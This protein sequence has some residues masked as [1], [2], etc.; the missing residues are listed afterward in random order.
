MSS[1]GTLGSTLPLGP[2]SFKCKHQAFPHDGSTGVKW[3]TSA[4]PPVTDNHHGAG[5]KGPTGCGR[6]AREFLGWHRSYL[7]SS[8]LLLQSLLLPILY[9]FGYYKKNKKIYPST[10]LLLGWANISPQVSGGLSVL[11]SYLEEIFPCL[12]NPTAIAVLI[13]Q[14]SSVQSLSRVWL[15]VTPWTAARQ[16]SLSITNSLCPPKPMPIESVMPSN[17]LILCHPLLLLPLIFPSIR[18]FSNESAFSSG[19]L[20]VEISASTSVLLVNI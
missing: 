2:K 1:I 16:A 8:D 5:A 10:P 20:S 13:I 17:H 12:Q 9:H 3:P 15:F 18:V 6:Y 19:G 4:S 14:F 11:L 7:L